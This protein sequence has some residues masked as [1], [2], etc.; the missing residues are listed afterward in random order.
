MTRDLIPDDAT[1]ERCARATYYAALDDAFAA[2]R[3]WE[4][5]SYVDRQ[6]CRAIARAV[7]TEAL[8]PAPETPR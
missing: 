6:Q 3:P 2:A 1:V 8:Q 5:A 4:T 7:L